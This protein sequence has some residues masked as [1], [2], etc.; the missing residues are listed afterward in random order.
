MAYYI[1]KEKTA[2]KEL[3][4]SYLDNRRKDKITRS[5]VKRLSKLGYKVTLKE[6]V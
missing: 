6:A 5:Y 3:G 1:L 4:A 2:Y